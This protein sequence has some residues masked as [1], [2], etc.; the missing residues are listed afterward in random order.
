MPLGARTR[1][2][3]IRSLVAL[4]E[5]ADLVY[6]R[7]QLIEEI[8]TREDL[9][10]TALIPGVALPHPHFPVPYDIAAS[11]V[12]VGL[13]PSGIPFGAPDGKL[14]R[15]FFMI[16]CKDDRTHLHVLARLMRMLD[17]RSAREELF[18]AESPEQLRALLQQAEAAALGATQ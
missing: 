12:V 14:T 16:C 5:Q 15:L 10:S 6:D 1:Q 11:F 18:H 3:A 7:D 2:A 4:A 13:T 8:R 9:C 17:D